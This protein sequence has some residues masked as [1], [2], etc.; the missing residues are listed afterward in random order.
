MS[1]FD[2]GKLFLVERDDFFAPDHTRFEHVGFVNRADL[3]SARPSQFE[4]SASDTAYL[5]GGVLFRVEASPL[6][7][8]KFLDAARLTEIDSAREFSYDDEVDALED[9]SLKRRGAGQRRICH[10][11]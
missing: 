8:R 4:R 7:V 9:F 11:R 3:A 1:E 6:P 5:I 10:D 2:I